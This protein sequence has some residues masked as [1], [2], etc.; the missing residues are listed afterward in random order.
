M[1]R[2]GGAVSTA[3]APASLADEAVEHL[4]NLIRIDTTNPPGNEAP[5]AQYVATVLAKEG[6]EARIL[7]AAPGRARVI[8]RLRATEPRRPLGVGDAGGA[9]LLVSHLDVV[10]A[11]RSGWSRNPFGG[12]IVDG[13]VFGRGAVDCKGM[14]ALSLATL[15][16]L[17]RTG[18]RLHRDVA[19]VAF[20]DEEAGS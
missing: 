4:R 11:E 5:A 19:L 13:C 7:E 3:T 8:A 1:P 14:T 18:K 17:K 9:L 6:I 2:P 10:P 15:C 16:H 12:D 20:A